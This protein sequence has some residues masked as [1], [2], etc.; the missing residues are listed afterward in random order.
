VARLRKARVWPNYSQSRVTIE[1]AHEA[2]DLIDALAAEIARLRAKI[3]E[4][5]ARGVAMQNDAYTD[6]E[7]YIGYGWECAGE[8]LATLAQ[9]TQ[10]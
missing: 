10:S 2:A 4:V 6:G 5:K 7:K 8:W 3:A 9:E 1:T